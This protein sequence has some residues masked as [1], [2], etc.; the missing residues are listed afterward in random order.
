MDGPVWQGYL[1]GSS[2]TAPW[3]L[4][5]LIVMG[6]DSSFKLESMPTGVPTFYAHNILF[7]D[8]VERIQ[9]NFDLCQ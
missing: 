5:L 8:R 1:A 2:K 3:I 4:I 7:P 9:N 6:A